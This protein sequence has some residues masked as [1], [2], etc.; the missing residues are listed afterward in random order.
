MEFSGEHI[1][2]F[3]QGDLKVFERIHRNMYHSLCLFGGKISAETDVVDD[4][5]Q[6][7]F[8]ALWRKR[9][10]LDNIFRIKAYLYTTVKNKLLTHI[11]LKKT[12]SLEYTLIEIDDESLNHQVFR[13]EVYKVLRVEISK[14]PER[15]RLVINFKMNGYTNKEIAK[16]LDISINTVKTLQRAGYSKLRNQ[17]KDNLI[18]VLLIAKLL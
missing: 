4:A 5:V 12:V 13:E 10:D 9:K 15:T 16:A 2:N 3:T 17:L 8:I 1:K 11:R 14:L 7:A 6:E 18:V